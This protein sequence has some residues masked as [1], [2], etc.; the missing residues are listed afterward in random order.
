MCT[1]EIQQMRDSLHRG[2]LNRLVIVFTQRREVE[3][4]GSGG[5]LWIRLGGQFS[6]VESQTDDVFDTPSLYDVPCS[7]VSHC[8]R[9]QFMM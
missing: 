7:F 9:E 1:T 5:S 3:K 8:N 6:L 2:F 4:R